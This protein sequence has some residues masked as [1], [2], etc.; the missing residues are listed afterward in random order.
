MISPEDFLHPSRYGRAPRLRVWRTIGHT[1]RIALS[2]FGNLVRLSWLWVAGV[3]IFQAASV[4]SA[5]WAVRHGWFDPR[6]AGNLVNLATIAISLLAASAIAAAWHRH[7]VLGAPI[8]GPAPLGRPAWRY[9]GGLIQIFGVVLIPVL[10]AG[11]MIV[12]GQHSGQRVLTTI[13]LAVGFFVIVMMALRFSLNPVSRAVG[14]HRIS[15]R[16]SWRLT[17]RNGLRILFCFV[18]VAWPLDI[19]DRIIERLMETNAVSGST[20]AI[21]TGYALLTVIQFGLAILAVTL[22]NILYQV[23]EGSAPGAGGSL[24]AAGG[25][26]PAG[27]GAG[28]P[29]RP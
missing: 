7:L 12:V 23:F 20:V 1:F 19:L 9:L 13:V 25:F 16:E 15:L 8:R 14:G 2:G 24:P 27:G 6:T 18:I 5:V 3:V 26:S 11:A 17:R 29:G 22:A 4:P 21:E 10:L 28:T